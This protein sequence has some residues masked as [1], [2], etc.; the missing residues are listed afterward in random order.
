MPN[1]CLPKQHAESFR[2]ALA[3]GTID[4][5]K[6]LD[7]TS[8]ERREF[9]EPIV[10]TENAKDVNASF[11]S[12]LALKNITQGIINWA[13]ANSGDNKLRPKVGDIPLIDKLLAAP[14]EKDFKADLV[15]KKLRTPVSFEQAQ[16]YTKTLGELQKLR[17]LS[18]EART[19]AL[20]K[21]VG[22][23]KAEAANLA[24][25]NA[26]TTNSPAKG[27]QGMAREIARI[28]V[29]GSKA[30]ST[31]QRV[32]QAIEAGTVDSF[33]RDFVSEKLGL[34][35][36]KVTYD[37]AQKI[38]DLAKTVREAE[39]KLKNENGED[40]N[41]RDEK[42][43]ST[44]ATPEEEAFGRA[45]N[46]LDDYIA[47]LKI[48]EFDP[49]ILRQIGSALGK[50]WEAPRKFITIGHGGVIPFTHSRTSMLTPGEG[51]I[52]W[53]AVQRA[54]S[55]A[56]GKR[57]AGLLGEGTP[58]WSR[59]MAALRS[60]PLYGLA[61]KSGL[62]V[63]RGT[64]PIGMGMGRWTEQ[65]FDALKGMR[66]D[67]FKKYYRDMPKDMQTPETAKSLATAI[68]HATGTAH[69][70]T[71]VNQYAGP[72]MFA[73]KLRWAKYASVV[74]A[75]TSK[76]AAKRAAKVIAVNIGLLAMNDLVNRYLFSKTGD[77]TVNWA[78]PSRPDW[79]RAK[80][81]GMTVPMS[82]LMETARLPFRVA[83]VMLDPTETDKFKV[84]KQE[85]VSAAHPAIPLGYGAVTGKEMWSGKTLPFKGVSQ[86]IYG[87]KRNQDADKQID[88]KEFG[89]GFTP[90]PAQPILKGLFKNN[91]QLLTE[92]KH[93]GI[94]L[95][96]KTLVPIVEMLASGLLGEHVYED[97]PYDDFA[98][99]GKRTKPKHK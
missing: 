56:P 67:L 75:A 30:I 98:K 6:M 87:D 42:A 27:S 46:D 3:D 39:S 52:F 15:A 45:Q 62:E 72:V 89:S 18:S 47:S 74:D 57:A 5:E 37:E 68:N 36:D 49:T 60:D 71:I 78:D 99:G 66:F 91:D 82:P 22:E 53:K 51:K 12:K 14:T 96:K 86:Y 43:G 26:M 34:K 58:R 1:W 13:E 77:D 20:A 54:Y 10:G 97:V 23:D 63:K 33:K 55:Y 83:D 84:I 65:S 88:K 76:F 32:Q 21:I 9:L 7:M 16:T 8:Q 64:K 73:P 28:D 48:R 94:N 70:P 35:T 59:D 40:I 61:E 19:E 90:I 25:E 31:A 50:V 80:V 41:R 24:Y 81:A 4:P 69:T 93:E 44:N 38:A 29:P 11:E 17:P 85:L 92:L 79:L 95:D 2:K